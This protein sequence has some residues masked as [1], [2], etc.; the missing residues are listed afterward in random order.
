MS[1]QATCEH[2]NMR[3]CS[4]VWVIFGWLWVVGWVVVVMCCSGLLRV[5]MWVVGD[6]VGLSCL[7]VVVGCC[8]IVV[9]VGCFRL[10]SG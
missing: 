10:W 6:V 4:A 7:W 1:E 9:V 5:V 3:A 2:A 8:W